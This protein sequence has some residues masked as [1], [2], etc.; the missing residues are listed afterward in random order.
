MLPELNS[1]KQFENILKEKKL[2][3]AISGKVIAASEGTVVAEL[4]RITQGSFCYLEVNSKKRILGK[5]VSYSG[6]QAKI[7]LLSTDNCLVALG[8]KVLILG[9]QLKLE[10]P[11]EPQGKILDSA[12]NI[13]IDLYGH[14]EN[15][16]KKASINIFPSKKEIS[17]Y[18][19]VN[20]TLCTGLPIIDS[21]FT[22]GKGQKIG[23]FA[24]AGI[25]KTSLIQSILQESESEKIVLCLVGERTREIS[26]TIEFLKINPTLLKKTVLVCS[27]SN[28]SS[29]QRALAP[30]TAMAIA[31]HFEKSGDSV[32]YILDSLSRFG[33]ALR[34]LALSIGEYP[35]REGYPVSV[36]TQLPRLIERAGNWGQSSITALFTV[37][38]EN[39]EEIG[40][41][42]AEEAKSLLDGHFYLSKKYSE[43]LVFPPINPLKSL[44]R[45]KFRVDDQNVIDSKRNVFST[46]WKIENELD[47]LSIA[48]NKGIELEKLKTA[49]KILHELISSKYV[50][51]ANIAEAYQ[52]LIET[53]NKIT[54]LGIE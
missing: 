23:V 16:T 49:E 2:D 25:G 47:L 4:P 50:A 37:L 27:S 44:S 3:L 35:S 26:E 20:T 53:S 22:I 40:D 18:K 6:N 39:I 19:P 5:V 15:N 10:I 32:L 46:L 8:T 7:S 51:G 17:C 12:G 21:L 31:E 36:F 41:V 13:I 38:L 9:D 52:M 1:V 34:D 14:D 33:R 42:F 30:F 45:I 11:N 48:D 28:E 24:Q 54:K 29:A 43:R